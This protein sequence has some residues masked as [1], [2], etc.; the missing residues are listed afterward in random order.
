MHIVCLVAFASRGETAVLKFLLSL[1][2]P[3]ERVAGIVAS[4]VNFISGGHKVSVI[5]RSLLFRFHGII[6]III[7]MFQPVKLPRASSDL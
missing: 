3:C 4:D 1:L 6:C 2:I 5:E 7:T